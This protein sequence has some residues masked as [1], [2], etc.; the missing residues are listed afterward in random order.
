[1]TRSWGKNKDWFTFK[2][3][4][5]Y[6]VENSYRCV[7]FHMLFD[8]QRLCQL[9]NTFWRRHEGGMLLGH[10]CVKRKGWRRKNPEMCV[11][12]KVLRFP[13]PTTLLETFLPVKSAEKEQ[14]RFAL[15]IF[16][17]VSRWRDGGM[18]EARGDFYICRQFLMSGYGKNF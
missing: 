2:S 7:H 4:K 14:M 1:M 6:K 13:L 17:S 12:D 3:L 8:F 16:I 9:K 10:R 18:E 11:S 15:Q 5:N